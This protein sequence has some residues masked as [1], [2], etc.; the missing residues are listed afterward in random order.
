MPGRGEALG[1]EHERPAAGG[2]LLL[3]G[4]DG[5]ALAGGA[6]EVSGGRLF[7]G[8]DAAG[9]V[10]ADVLPAP[11]GVGDAGLGELD[12]GAWPVPAAHGARTDEARA[13]GERL[14][15]EGDDAV[16]RGREQENGHAAAPVR[17]AASTRAGW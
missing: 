11:H 3:S 14:D 7:G 8:E 5:A 16:C 15:V 4:A 17:C 10:A 9:A 1:A 13:D 6:D 2:L 12:A